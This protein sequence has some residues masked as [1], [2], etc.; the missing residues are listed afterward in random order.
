MQAHRPQ[1]KSTVLVKDDQGLEWVA[2]VERLVESRNGQF[3]GLI[4][5]LQAIQ[6][7]YGY[8]PETA[9]RVV[10][11]LTG[12]PLVDVY[13]LATF[14]RAF[15]MVP[16]GK[17]VISVCQGT[18]CHIRGAARPLE[19]LQRQ[20]G[21]K[22]GQTTPDG[23]FYL[24]T[25]NCLGACALGPVVVVDGTYYPRVDNTKVRRILDQVRRNR[26]AIAAAAASP[27]IR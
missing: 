13:G 22:G 17:H 21:I 6:A 14:Y 12:R 18:A 25:V 2:R 19:E 15:S 16:R 11:R 23:Q 24:E 5:I 26:P 20:L 9:L 1:V 3:G 4:G 8:L 7:E 27:A 10:S